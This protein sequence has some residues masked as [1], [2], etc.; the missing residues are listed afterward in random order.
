MALS[1]PR[2]KRVSPGTSLMHNRRPRIWMAIC[3]TLPK[4]PGV[5]RVTVGISDV[6]EPP[7][8]LTSRRAVP[9]LATGQRLGDATGATRWI[10]GLRVPARFVRPQRLQRRPIDI[11][12]TS[13]V[14]Q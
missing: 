1:V 4:G 13:A 14:V 5:D 11:T 6:I 12:E 8:E 7:Q 3:R 9:H 10:T 2:A